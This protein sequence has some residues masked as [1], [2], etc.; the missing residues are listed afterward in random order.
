MGYK[1]YNQLVN[2]T[3]KKKTHRYREQTSGYQC[4]GGTN[5]RV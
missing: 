3:E 5:Y 4:W 2:K 1:T